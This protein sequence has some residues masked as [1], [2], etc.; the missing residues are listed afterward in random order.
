[1]DTSINVRE[2]N[3]Q[4]YVLNSF[5]SEN[6]VI[7]LSFHCMDG[8]IPSYQMIMAPISNFLKSEF[9]L[10]SHDKIVS[11][12]MPDY[13]RSEIMEYLLDLFNYNNIRHA[14]L[15]QL[16]GCAILGSQD[17]LDEDFEDDLE[18]NND[19]NEGNDMNNQK[20]SVTESFHKSE[21]AIDDGSVNLKSDNNEHSFIEAQINDLSR[22]GSNTFD[23]VSSE[24]FPKGTTGRLRSIVWD[25]FYMSDKH[26]NI[27]RHC[28]KIINSSIHGM[29]THLAH[30]HGGLMG[31]D[32][33][34]R[35]LKNRVSSIV[36][37]H[38]ERVDENISKCNHCGKNIWSSKGS[39]TEMRKHLRYDH[40]HIMGKNPGDK[41]FD[42]RSSQRKGGSIVWEHFEK[43]NEESSSCKHCGKYINSRGGT[44]SGMR[45]HL[46]YAHSHVMDEEFVQKVKKLHSR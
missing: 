23:V 40:D 5:S 41:G 45:V 9:Q 34:A 46:A 27:C 33:V 42:I 15:N 24:I 29:R 44:T 35:V 2:N 7:D 14:E 6:S 19:D 1:M 18:E 37:D 28:E 30:V 17:Y 10:N 4:Q 3:I 22:I 8:H 12:L 13:G 11:I 21:E 39:T 32:F 36:W 26:S 20:P 25:H 16:L 38:F 31:Q 43:I